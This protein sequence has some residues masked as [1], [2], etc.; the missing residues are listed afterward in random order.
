MPHRVLVTQPQAA[1]CEHMIALHDIRCELGCDAPWHGNHCIRAAL[2]RQRHF[3]TH[4]MCVSA[5]VVSK[6]R[7]LCK[8]LRF[9]RT[10]IGVTADGFC[11]VKRLLVGAMNHA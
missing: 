8:Y 11:Q 10:E 6:Q 9:L 1:A 7:K 5:L 3:Q 4:R 2:K